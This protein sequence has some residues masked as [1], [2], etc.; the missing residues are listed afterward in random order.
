MKER[1]AP[2]LEQA[3]KDIGYV[4]RQA[5]YAHRLYHVAVVPVLKRNGVHKDIIQIVDNASVEAQLMF[6]RKLNEFFKPLPKKNNL[7]DDDLRAEHYSGF[8]SPGAFLTGDQEREIHKRVGHI[9]L[10]EARDQQMDWTKLVNGCLPIAVDRLLTFFYFLRD[11]YPFLS[12]AAARKEVH[13]SINQLERLVS[14]S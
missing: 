9:T 14:R 6:L 8:Q 7:Q 2:E 10:K 13:L 5:C 11:E 4:M 12:N 3:I 1:T